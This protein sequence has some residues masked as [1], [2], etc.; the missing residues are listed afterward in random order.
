MKDQKEISDSV[1]KIKTFTETK[2]KM[3]ILTVKMME[4]MELDQRSSLSTL[5][6]RILFQEV[7][8]TM[9]KKEKGEERRDEKIERFLLTQSSVQ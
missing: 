8:K 1:K 9:G 6:K 3:R 4:K 5:T 2:M 7:T